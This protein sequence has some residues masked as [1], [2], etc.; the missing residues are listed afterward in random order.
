MTANVTRKPQ[1]KVLRI[2]F[3]QE[4]TLLRECLIKSGETVTVGESLRNTLVFP[5]THLPARFPLIV[6][7]GGDYVLQLTDDMGGKVSLSKGHVQSIDEM[8]ESGL[9]KSKK[10]GYQLDLNDSSKGRIDVSNLTVL[11]QF[12]PPPPEPLKSMNNY[13]FRPKPFK[14]L[15]PVFLSF[16]SLSTALS[17]VLGIF[18]FTAEPPP[19][20]TM[21]E[22]P[23]RFKIIKIDK[24][25]EDLKIID[26]VVDESD[27]LSEEAEEIQ[28]EESNEEPPELEEKTKEKIA[29][30]PTE[31]QID[32]VRSSPLIKFIDS[33]ASN[34]GGNFI[35]AE[36]AMSDDV[37]SSLSDVNVASIASSNFGNKSSK[38]GQET[39]SIG[40]ISS[41]ANVGVS[42]TTHVETKIKVAVKPGTV[43]DVDGSA[44]KSDVDKFRK[45]MRSKYSKQIQ[46]CYET[47]LKNKP[48]LSGRIELYIE[49]EDSKVVEFEFNSTQIKDPALEKCITK[50]A[51]GWSFPG[52]EADLALNY[53]MILTTQ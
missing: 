6:A 17:A 51:G 27:N 7:K 37:M 52:L 42:K 44:D 46:S 15:D 38:S 50:R 47:S 53:P 39:A 28:S 35:S 1:D 24:P 8:K 2:G 19:K 23:D 18:A 14:T 25:V 13:D 3:V 33:T 29:D 10:G 4:G 48:S 9:L 41:T 31:E 43:E 16:L 34:T 45:R 36:T 30:A 22:I 49:I 5:S 12:V 11:F 32:K 20:P 21:D 26:K 40:E